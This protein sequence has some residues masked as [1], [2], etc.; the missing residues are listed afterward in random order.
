MSKN[1]KVW[2]P[3]IIAI[4]AAVLLVAYWLYAHGGGEP[5]PRIGDGGK[6]QGGGPRLPR[7]KEEGLGDYFT[8]IGTV[9]LYL[10]AGAFSWF[11]FKRKLKSPS[12]LVRKAGKL[13]YAAHKLLGWLTFAAIAVHGVYFLMTKLHDDKIYTGL[14]AFAILLALIGYGYLINKIRHKQMRLIHRLLGIS[15]VPA[16][17]LHAGGSVIAATAACLAVGGL[18]WVL[19]RSAGQADKPIAE[20]R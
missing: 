18:V 5:R 3:A 2:L 7:D 19:E 20:E 11:W 12:P 9:A 15:W 13:L 14:A 6:L 10:G 8:T 4:V 17:L 16:L 1:K